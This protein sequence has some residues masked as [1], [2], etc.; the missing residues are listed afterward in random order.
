MWF[1]LED[2][3]LTIA[4]EMV[5]SV[6]IGDCSEVCAES[7]ALWNHRN[8]TTLHCRASFACV[9]SARA[10]LCFV[11]EGLELCEIGFDL[12]EINILRTEL[13]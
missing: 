6:D 12:G 3:V 9:R 5:S 1:L 13:Q 4:K 7:F 10:R 8:I 2:S 11:E